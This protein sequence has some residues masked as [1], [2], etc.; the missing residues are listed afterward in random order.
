MNNGSET[1]ATLKAEIAYLRQRVQ[2][3]EQERAVSPQRTT[4]V[5]PGLQVADFDGWHRAALLQAVL[6]VFPDP[7]F[8]KDLQ[9]RWIA[10]NKGFCQLIGHPYEMIIGRSD[11]DLWPPEQAH[12]FWDADD[13]VFAGHQP[14]FNEE[15]A[16]GTDGVERTIWTRKFPM[17][18]KHGK[19]IGLCGIITDISDIKQRQQ[20][21][22]RLETELAG[23][24]QTERMTMQQELIDA[25]QEALRELSTPLI[26]L[27]NEIILLPLIGT[28]DSQ[29][30]QQVMEALLEGVAAYQAE[31][32][33]L[34]ITGVKVVDIQ[35]AEI[36]IRV[37]R[38]VKLLGAEIMITGIQPLMAQTLV[39]FGAD[40]SGIVTYATLQA[41]IAAVL[42]QHI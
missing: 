23:R 17:H 37:A 39:Q 9:H 12:V 33:I 1:T 4:A 21:I 14:I 32:A 15:L 3:L 20:R 40:L 10:C 6:D 41:G 25:Q 18:D 2:E 26:P 34:D 13:K 35:I 27:T 42:K 22:E 24:F 8:V 16:T 5:Q 28:I 30:A 29:R 38:A 31:V 36:F 11:P 19:V 7:I